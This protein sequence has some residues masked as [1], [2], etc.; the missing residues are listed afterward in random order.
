[1]QLV[2][3]LL[4]SNIS[5][6]K[7]LSLL[8]IENF[9]QEDIDFCAPFSTSYL[10]KGWI[11]TKFEFFMAKLKLSTAAYKHQMFDVK[12]SMISSFFQRVRYLKFI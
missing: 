1:M 5:K 6:S 9:I 3:L 2:I 12:A 11:V 8:Y 4:P 10:A 7:V